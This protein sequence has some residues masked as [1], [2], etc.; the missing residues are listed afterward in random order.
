MRYKGNLCPFGANDNEKQIKKDQQLQ[1]IKTSPFSPGDLQ[2]TNPFVGP[3][4]PWSFLCHKHIE[5][6]PII[7]HWIR[8]SRKAL[9][10]VT[11]K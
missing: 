9:I 6:F 8:S 10:D 1:K 11:L 4:T 2:V 7:I 5:T 3:V